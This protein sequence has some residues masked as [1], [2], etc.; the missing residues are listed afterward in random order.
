MGHTLARRTVNNVVNTMSESHLK[1][2]EDVIT[3]ATE[4]KWLI[5]LIVDDFTSIH[6]RPEKDQSSEAMTMCTIV[7]KAY[8]EI[9]AIAVEQA[10]HIH[11][12]NGIDIDSCQRLI[13]SAS[14]MHNISNCYAS[15]MPEGGFPLPRN[16]YMRSDVDFNWL[17]VRKLK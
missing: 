6:T 1:S 8:K 3:E 14:C 5:V 17:Y 11:D 15:V 13:T 12:Q 2:F 10:T 7:V 16:F 4:R 9:P